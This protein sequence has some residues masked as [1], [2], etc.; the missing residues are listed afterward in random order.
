MSKK[1]SELQNEFNMALQKLEAEQKK[2][3]EQQDRQRKTQED[4]DKYHD[5]EERKCNEKMQK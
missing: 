5:E 4:W 1:P 3:K 2:N